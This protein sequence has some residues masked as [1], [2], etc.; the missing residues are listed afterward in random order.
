M[1]VRVDAAALADTAQ[2]GQSVLEDGLH[3]PAGTS[4]RPAC[5]ATRVVMR[6]DAD[7]RVTEVGARTRTILPALR[8]A[9]LHRNQGCR[10]PGCGVRIGQAHH[11]QHWAQG[12][13]TKLS[14]LT[15]LCRRRHRAVH[16]EGYQLD[17]LPSGELRV[18]RPD[19]RP[20]SATRSTSFTRG[21]AV[22]TPA[23]RPA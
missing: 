16:E 4:Q 21:P 8:R 9:L 11:I 17:R 2:P 15:L 18:R 3:V 13:P 23:A 7:G 19:G 5:D 20:T 14:N 1:V 22:L 6:H 10:F 12:G